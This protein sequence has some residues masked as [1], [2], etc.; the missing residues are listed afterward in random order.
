MKG[1]Q[2]GIIPLPG[3]GDRLII[4]IGKHAA[5]VSMLHKYTTICSDNMSELCA[6]PCATLTIP[7]LIRYNSAFVNLLADGVF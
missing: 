4:M 6:A 7:V 2:Q 1:Q 3:V 5:S